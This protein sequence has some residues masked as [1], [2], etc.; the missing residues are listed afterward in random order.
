VSEIKTMARKDPVLAA[1]GAV[2]L[3]EKLSPA[4]E[5]VD[6]SSRAAIG[7]AVNR[8][9]NTLV[10]IIA[11]APVDAGLRQR[12]LQRLWAAVADDGMS[13]IESLGGFLG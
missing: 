2:I 11:A 5:R 12:W 1:E 10:P 9:I 3:L 7:S 4:L 13:S 8:A 6:S